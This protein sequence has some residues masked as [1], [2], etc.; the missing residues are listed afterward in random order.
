[1]ASSIGAQVTIRIGPAQI[2]SGAE[3]ADDSTVYVG[4][5]FEIHWVLGYQAFWSDADGTGYEHH[6]LET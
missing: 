1:M 6:G 2:G 3:T 4:T 5:W